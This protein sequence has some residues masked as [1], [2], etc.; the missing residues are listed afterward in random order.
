MTVF[1][2]QIRKLRKR[3]CWVEP[4]P[5]WA[6]SYTHLLCKVQDP[7]SACRQSK[8][9]KKNISTLRSVLM[10]D[11]S[12]LHRSRSSGRDFVGWS[13]L[14]CGPALTPISCTK[15]KIHSVHADSRNS[16]TKNI[17]TLRSVLMQD[18]SLLHR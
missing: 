13:Q 10:Q 7:F 3:F 17:S 9:K 12:L 4:A 8:F 5:L 1:A 11:L 6:S 2:S 16:K 14:P 18:L 15:S